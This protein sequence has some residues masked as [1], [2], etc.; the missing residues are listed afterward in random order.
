MKWYHWIWVPLAVAGAIIASLLGRSSLIGPTEAAKRELKAIEAS[1][2]AKKETVEKGAQEALREIE[3]EHEEAIA[4]L[5]AKQR[6]KASK[7]RE[8][9]AKLAGFLVRAGSRKPG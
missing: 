1:E 9:P 7:L 4:E 6:R 5:S 8:N 3:R 2:K